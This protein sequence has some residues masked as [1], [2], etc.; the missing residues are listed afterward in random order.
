MRGKTVSARAARAEKGKGGLSAGHTVSA[1]VARANGQ[2]L[3]VCALAR[4]VGW[5]AGKRACGIAGV[6]RNRPRQQSRALRAIESV[7]PF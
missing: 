4:R 5:Q 7:H 1:R 3:G 2:G 6:H